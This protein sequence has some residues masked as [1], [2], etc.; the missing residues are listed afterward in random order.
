[1]SEG[2][3]M[4]YESLCSTCKHSTIFYD[5]HNSW[6][7]KNE[8][9][10]GVILGHFIYTRIKGCGQYK[11]TKENNED[12]ILDKGN[13]TY[14][15]RIQKINDEDGWDIEVAH[16]RA[17]DLLCEI[18]LEH[19]HDEVVEIFKNMHKWYA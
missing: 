12:G 1:M 14:I 18:L 9:A 17:D 16:S 15:K 4:F 3:A 11:P 2:R 6:K 10:L 13:N 19:G 7:C 8:K 5:S